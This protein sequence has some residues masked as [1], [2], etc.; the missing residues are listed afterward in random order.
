CRS[1][2]VVRSVDEIGAARVERNAAVDLQT[3]EFVDD[4]AERVCLQL[5]DVIDADAE[6]LFGHGH[7]DRPSALVGD[8]AERLTCLD[9]SRRVEHE[10]GG[11]VAG[12]GNVD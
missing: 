9:L 2:E 4:A 7:E 3:A 11:E 10:Y 1:V 6:E 8:S 12:G 5:C